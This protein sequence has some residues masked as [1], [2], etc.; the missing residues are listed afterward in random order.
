MRKVSDI[1]LKYGQYLMDEQPRL[2]VPHAHWPTQISSNPPPQPRNLAM[3]ERYHFRQVNQKRSADPLLSLAL[4][5]MRQRPESRANGSPYRPLTLIPLVKVIT[6]HSASE[7]AR[8]RRSP[9]NGSGGR[10]SRRMRQSGSRRLLPKPCPTRS[11]S[12]R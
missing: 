6:T 8:M 12:L 9:R 4:E 11:A 10:K 3:V 7:I 5:R 1:T 2:G